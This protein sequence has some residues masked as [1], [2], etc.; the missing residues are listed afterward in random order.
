M[1]TS[2]EAASGSFS[3]AIGSLCGHSSSASKTTLPWLPS[4]PVGLG[5]RILLLLCPLSVATTSDALQLRPSICNPDVLWCSTLPCDI[6]PYLMFQRH[7][8]FNILQMKSSSLVKA[9]FSTSI[10]ELAAT[11]DMQPPTHK[12]I[13][14]MSLT[15]IS[16]S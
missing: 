4:Q 6:P 11:F 10:P 14:E 3:H 8:S 2:P 5:L 12:H 15:P 7:V 13:W 16:V 9:I 1:L